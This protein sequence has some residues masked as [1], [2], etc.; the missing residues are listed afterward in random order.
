MGIR[1]CRD[2]RHWRR[3]GDFHG[4]CGRIGS[5]GAC[6]DPQEPP[7]GESA[8]IQL[9]GGGIRVRLETRPEFGCYLFERPD[10]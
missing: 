9:A 4:T 3:A 5:R 2:C 10:T 1:H 8:Q 7:G 6:A